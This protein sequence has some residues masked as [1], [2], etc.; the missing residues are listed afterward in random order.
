MLIIILVSV[1][2]VGAIVGNFYASKKGGKPTADPLT[3]NTPAVEEPAKEVET[4]VSHTIVSVVEPVKKQVSKNTAKQK[5]LAKM[6]AKPKK[7]AQV[8][9]KSS[10]KGKE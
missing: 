10:K 7:K 3:F 2:A 8:I 1:L 9:D 6:E 5:P 4:V